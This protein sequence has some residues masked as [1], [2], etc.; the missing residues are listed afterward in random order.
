M[1]LFDLTIIRFLNSFA[2]R[3]LSVDYAVVRI[4]DNSFLVG[5]VMMIL[6]WWAWG[7]KGKERRE[8]EETLVFGIVATTFAV[9]L[10]RFLAWSLPFRERPLHN[11]LLHF[12]LP[13]HVKPETLIGWSSFP[14]DHAVV[15]FCMAGILWFVSR[16]LGACAIGYAALISIPRIY[17]GFHYPTDI[18][19]GA[20]LGAGVAALSQIASLRKTVSHIFWII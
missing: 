3:S 19:G 10:A 9:F 4:A 17:L 6:F 8:K 12:Q 2:H 1:N 15:S 5:G 18:L 14:S 13:Y 16:R 7:E 11:P 20:L